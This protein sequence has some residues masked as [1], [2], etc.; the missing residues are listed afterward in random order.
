MVTGLSANEARKPPAAFGL[1]T[2]AGGWSEETVMKTLKR[3]S[4]DDIRVCNIKCAASQWLQAFTST[5][6]C[7]YKSSIERIRGK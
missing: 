5:R 1:Q 6:V 2:P 7:V 4:Q 3:L